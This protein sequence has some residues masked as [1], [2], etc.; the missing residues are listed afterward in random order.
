MTKQT[1]L[2]WIATIATM[3]WITLMRV[4]TPKNIVQFEFAK[5]VPTV[6]EIIT[7]W[8]LE[9]IALAKTSIYLDFI[10]IVLYCSAIMLGC[11]VAST[12]SGKTILIK[13]GVGLSW[14][15]WFAGLCDAIENFAMLKTLEVVNQPTISIAFYFAAIK[16][17]IVVMALLFTIISALAGL[18]NRKNP[19]IR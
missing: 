3:G 17:A 9:G 1:K 19:P 14:L 16:F 7:T 15:I 5:T 13:I 4:Y 18:I 10:F 11:K 6:N 12:Y 2:F 8:G